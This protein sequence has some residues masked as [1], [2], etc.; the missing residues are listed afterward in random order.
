MGLSEVYYRLA[1]FL[2]SYINAWQRKNQIL[3]HLSLWKFHS[4]HRC[5]VA[6]LPLCKV[7]GFAKRTCLRQ[8][9]SSSTFF[10]FLIHEF[11]WIPGAVWWLGILIYLCLCV[12]F[13]WSALVCM[14]FSSAWLLQALQPQSISQCV[15]VCMCVGGCGR[16]IFHLTPRFSPFLYNVTFKLYLWNKHFHCCTFQMENLSKF[17]SVFKSKSGVVS[18]NKGE[19]TSSYQW[20]KSIFHCVYIY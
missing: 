10:T 1:F 7:T 11:N 16:F 9:Y 15:G 17:H 5:L 20:L 2:S 6:S 14:A 18:K 8:I 19:V 3:P 4:S 12:K 13:A